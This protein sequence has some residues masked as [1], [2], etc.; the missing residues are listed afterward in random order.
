MGKDKKKK[1]ISKNVHIKNRKA[2]FDYQFLDKYIAGVVLT[3]TEIKSIRQSQVVLGDAFC[4]FKD[5]ELWLK[6]M[7]IAPYE[8]GTHYNHE[9]TRERKLL[10]NKKELKKISKKLAEKGLSVVPTRL[11]INDRGLAKIE[12]AVAR[13]KKLYDKRESMK[14]RD[15]KRELKNY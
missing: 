5:E 4:F 9:P 10:L 7:H 8:N 14:E 3:G 11:F 15:S 2:S 13:G 1:E 6:Q 12:V